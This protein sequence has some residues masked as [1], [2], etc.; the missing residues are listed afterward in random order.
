MGSGMANSY[1]RSQV[2]LGPTDL[3]SILE[4][5]LFLCN[6]LLRSLD[7]STDDS[8]SDRDLLGVPG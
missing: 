6:L 2:V 4:E 8:N 7:V 5:P 1:R 3:V